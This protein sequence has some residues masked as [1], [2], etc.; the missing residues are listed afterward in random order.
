MLMRQKQVSQT[1]TF[2]NRTGAAGVNAFNYLKSKRGDPYFVLTIG[3]GS[4]LTAALRPDLELP[5]ETFT[6]LGFFAQDPQVI[7]VN[8]DTKF[9]SIKDLVAAGKSEPNSIVFGVATAGGAGRYLIHMIERETG[10]KYKFVSFK[11]SSEAI[12]AVLGGHIPAT[13]ENLSEMLQYVEAKK[14]RVLAVTGEKRL[15]VIP[16]VPTLKELGM[17]IVVGT[18]RGFVMSAGVPKE[19]AAYM[20]AALKRVHDSAEWKAF[21]TKNLYEDIYMSAADFSQYLVREREK[22]REFQAVIGLGQKP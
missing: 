3:S 6:P 10:A 13:T 2:N 9:Q 5:L 21:A 17:P 15:P 11:G 22:L 7:A 19:A 4:L 12:T 20:E 1:I 8:I 16:N 14:L 18:G